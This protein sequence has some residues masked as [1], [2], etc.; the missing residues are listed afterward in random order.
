MFIIQLWLF[1][2]YNYETFGVQPH[3]IQLLRE[4]SDHYAFSSADITFVCALAI[5]NGFPKISWFHNNTIIG[6]GPHYSVSSKGQSI[7]T[8]TV[9]NVSTE[10]QGDYHCCVYDWKTKLR[11]KPGRLYGKQH[12]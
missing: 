7:N 8:L 9:R 11:S 12:N 6:A 5:S 3:P 1:L 10:D 2:E 4:P